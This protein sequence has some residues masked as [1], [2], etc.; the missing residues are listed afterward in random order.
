MKERREQANQKTNPS[1]ITSAKNYTKKKKTV[2]TLGQM[3][4]AKLYRQ[5]HTKKHTHGHSQKEKKGKKFI[6]IKIIFKGRERP[7]QQTNLP[8]IISSKY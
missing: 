7:N 2:R 3:T 6:Y 5:N 1:M 4:K 8:M